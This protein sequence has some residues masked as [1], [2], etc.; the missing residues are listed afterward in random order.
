MSE[1][2]NISYGELAELERMFNEQVAARGVVFEDENDR[3]EALFDFY[4]QYIDGDDKPQLR[5]L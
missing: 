4:Q 2:R 1:Q 5:I 3:N